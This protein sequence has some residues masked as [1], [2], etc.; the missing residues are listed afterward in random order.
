[1]FMPTEIIVVASLALSLFLVTG[2][3]SVAVP[4][5]EEWSTPYES[6]AVRLGVRNCSTSEVTTDMSALIPPLNR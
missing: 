6:A 3:W 1:M 4:D 2:V 5:V